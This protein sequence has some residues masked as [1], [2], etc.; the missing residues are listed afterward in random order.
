[1]KDRE[2]KILKEEKRLERER[3]ALELSFKTIN[4]EKQKLEEFAKAIQNKSK[5]VEIMSKVRS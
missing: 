1:M 5:E 2:S 3:N 4:E